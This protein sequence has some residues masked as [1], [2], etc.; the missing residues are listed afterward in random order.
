MHLLQ[1]ADPAVAA[2][3][4]AATSELSAEPVDAR[5]LELAA[6]IQQLNMLPEAAAAHLPWLRTK[7]ADYGADVRARLLAGL[8]LPST[9]YP[10]G[11]RARR[12]LWDQVRT[13]FERYDI[14][15]APTMPIVAP[16][17]DEIPADYRLVLMPFNSPW[18]C[19]GLPVVSVPCGFVDGLPVGMALVGREGEDATVLRAAQALQQASDWHERRPEMRA[20]AAI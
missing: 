15:A 14:L 16:R 20:S 13:L 12:W 18:S 5:V 10:T 6:V 8:S 9:A 17:L 1:K 4:E 2:V 3:V 11:L 7:L 19:L